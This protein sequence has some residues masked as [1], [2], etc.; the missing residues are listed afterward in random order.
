ATAQKRKKKK[1]AETEQTPPP[2]PEKKE[3]K[4]DKNAIKAFEE[5]IESDSLSDDGLF[6]VHIAEDKYYFEIK[7]DVLGREILIV[8]RIASTVDNL[9]FGGAGMK[10]RPQ[11][12]VRWQKHN[13]QILLRS[14]SFNNV[15]SMD[16]PIY[17][18]VKNNNFEP[19]I[20]SFKIEAYNRDTTG[21]LID[22]TKLFTTDVEMIGALRQS[23]RKNF[24]ISG[25]DRDRSLISWMKSFPENVEVRHVL[26]Y[27]GK[28]LPD[29]RLTNTLSVE[30]NQS[31]IVLP[32]E[33][34]Q[35]RLHD[36]RVGYFSI[37]QTNY[38][39][40]EQKAAQRRYITR[41]RLEPSDVEAYQRGELVEP[42]KPIVYYIDPATPV[43]W[44]EYIKQGVNDWQVAF[45]AAGFKNAIYAKDPPSKEEDPDWSP[46]DVRYSVIRYITTD[47]QN[48]QG[49]HVHDPRS[50][51]ILESDI[52]WYHNVMNLLRN[53]YFIQTAPNNPA[54]Q[55]VKFEDEVMG[56]LIR[57][58]SAHEVGHTLGLPHNMGSS[59]AYP[60]DS[61]R[62]PT[63]TATHGTAP[64][65]MDYARFNYVAQPEDGVTN[66]Y[67]KI[68]EYDVWSIQYGYTY[69]PEADSPE[70]EHEILHEW[71]LEKADNPVYRY[72][73]QGNSADPSS[74]TEDLGD[75][76]VYASDLG[77]EN[78]KRIIP[79]LI[80]WTR[81]DGK[82][83]DE[84]DELYGQVFSQFRRYVGHVS[85]NIGGV[86]EY[87][88]TFDQDEPVYTPVDADKQ[89]A[90]VEFM[91]RQVFDT[92]KWLV[93]DAILGRIE[94]SGHMDR[95][96]NFQE[97]ALRRMFSAERLYRLCEGEALRGADA[98]PLSEMFTTVTDAIWSE[99][100]SNAEID[101]YR[102]NLQR[103][104]VVAMKE[105]LELDEEKYDQTDIKAYARHTLREI[106]RR[107]SS[108]RHTSEAKRVHLADISH[109][110]QKILDVSNVK[111][112]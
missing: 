59:V 108:R 66:F 11:Q 73:R 23:Q 105:L 40:D 9:N 58:V 51:E 84:L 3:E 91:S 95:M 7:D 8:S 88:K 48:A 45:E 112:S 60:V 32:E 21:Y 69:F 85:T 47:I 77:I 110:I 33:P 104:F 98:Y 75:D 102:R 103:A 111:K 68:G 55:A 36:A 100:N 20:E 53:W 106:Q 61:L 107:I 29:N 71:I 87:Y 41:W 39:L 10:S 27:N 65:I 42:V 50:G 28:N 34:M 6:G 70:D 92:P 19:I 63:F 24:Q 67:P 89:R 5:V 18:S 46:E 38:S 1:E 57:F 30:M 86:Y 81:Q 76:A 12:V 37:R 22:V 35:P 72:G 64:S 94:A 56:Q 25:L 17:E 96:R 52:L 31:F 97:G 49:P 109:R 14:V 4:K 79:K 43:K 101:I 62:S 74:Q 44:R 16:D 80:T 82:P 83:F 93:S 99:L 26:T 2:A 78:L 13:K 90:A 15:A 54:A